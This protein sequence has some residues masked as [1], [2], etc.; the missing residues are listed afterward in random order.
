MPLYN[1]SQQAAKAILEK[2]LRDA[3]RQ[4]AC[5]ALTGVIA[6]QVRKSE[7]AIVDKAFSL[8]RNCIEKEETLYQE[9][10]NA[11]AE[12]ALREHSDEQQME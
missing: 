3:F 9:W 6:G 7:D 11:V 12:E 10:K 8:A 2:E 1:R 4:Y 5:A